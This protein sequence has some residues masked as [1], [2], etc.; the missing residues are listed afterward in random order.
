MLLPL[1]LTF[2]RHLAQAFD[3]LA[4]FTPEDAKDPLPHEL[5]SLGATLRM[6]DITHGPELFQDM[7]QIQDQLDSFERGGDFALQGPFAVGHRDPDFLVLWI[8]A[9]HLRLH[10]GDESVLARKQAGPHALLLGPVIALGLL[11][12]RRLG[13]QTLHDGLWCPNIWF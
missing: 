9:P 12:P 10:L 5:A 7:Q 4:D 11:G 6:E 8:P 2:R 1:E 13:K 3:D